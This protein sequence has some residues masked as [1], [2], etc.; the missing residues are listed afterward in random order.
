MPKLR[1]CSFSLSVDGY[2]A[3]PHQ[4]LANPLGLGGMALHEWAFE[5]RTF[6]KIFGGEGRSTGDDR[7]AMRGFENIGAWIMGRNMF[8]PVRVHGLTKPGRGGWQQSPLRHARLRTDSLPARPARGWRAGP[9]FTSSLMESRSRFDTP[10]MRRTGATSGWVAASLR[11]GSPSSRADRRDAPR[12]CA[13]SAGR[14]GE[15]ISRHRCQKA[16]LSMQRAGRDDES[17]AH[18]DFKK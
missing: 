17:H 6:Q 4:D 18:S 16:R 9:H 10:K 13:G 7:F 15:P 2:G 11:S 12:H 3:G 5:T 8:G 14:R 1:V